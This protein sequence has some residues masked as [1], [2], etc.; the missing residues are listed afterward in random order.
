MVACKFGLT[1]DAADSYPDRTFLLMVILPGNAKFLSHP[2][3][4]LGL[5]MPLWVSLGFG[6]LGFGLLRVG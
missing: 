3:N 6:L 4:P 5:D 1:E 2:D